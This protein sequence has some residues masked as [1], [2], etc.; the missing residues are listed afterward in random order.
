MKVN[1][2]REKGITLVALV[3]TIVIL[4]ILA[5][6]SIATLTQTGL[7]GKVKL[8]KS[9]Y[10]NSEELENTTLKEYEEKVS[11]YIG[12]ASRNDGKSE[13]SEYIKSVNFSVN[14]GKNEIDITINT[15]I[16]DTSKILGYH[17]FVKDENNKNVIK[18]G[19]TM[20]NQIKVE[21]LKADTKYNVL[22]MAYDIDNNYKIAEIQQIQ[23]LSAPAIEIISTYKTSSINKNGSATAEDI[24]NVLFDGNIKNGG[25]YTGLLI[26]VG[27]L[28]ININR[29]VKI[30]AYS[31]LYT[32]SA[33][34]SGK[35]LVVQKYDG[36]SYQDYTTVST[37]YSGNKYELVTLEPGQYKIKAASL[38]V[39]FDEWEYKVIK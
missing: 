4:L 10:K 25:K 13:E 35:N 26:G 9:K 16:D 28:E 17:Y 5:G 21:G 15:S 37:N 24:T 14:I 31:N 8:A 3:V 20:S 23:T 29:K 34:R 2:K 6:I 22:I 38:Y 32:D 27:N 18:S 11:S 39:A 7:F 19:M 12:S 36:N 33:G 1:F 30:Y